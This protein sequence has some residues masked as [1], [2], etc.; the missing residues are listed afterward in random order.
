M[1][2]LGEG[3]KLAAKEGQ[4]VVDVILQV[5]L[6]QTLPAESPRNQR[7]STSIPIKIVR[8]DRSTSLQ[9]SHQRIVPTPPGMD[10]RFYLEG[11]HVGLA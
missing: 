9:Y 5:A 4:S 3:L 10:D 2:G 1:A 11:L 6:L 7:C 8:G